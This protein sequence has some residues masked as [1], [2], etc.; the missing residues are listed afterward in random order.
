MPIHH[1]ISAQVGNVHVLLPN[2]P[3]SLS[4][5]YW[6]A[7]KLVG[8]KALLNRPEEMSRTLADQLLHLK[9]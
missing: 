7:V 9:I 5:P 4:S 2:S 3:R 1:R 6:N 8:I